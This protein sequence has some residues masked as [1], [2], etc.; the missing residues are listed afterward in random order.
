M[1]NQD[2]L[3]TFTPNWRRLGSQEILMCQVHTQTDLVRLSSPLVMKSK[4]KLLFP[5]TDQP[6]EVVI[7]IPVAVSTLAGA[8]VKLGLFLPIL[9][10]MPLLTEMAG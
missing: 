9:H 7:S 10:S 3:H 1:G 5:S 2:Q 4:G 8:S 6:P